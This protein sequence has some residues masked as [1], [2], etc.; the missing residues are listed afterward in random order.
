M[1]KRELNAKQILV[2]ILCAASMQV[3]SAPP[4]WSA[5]PVGDAAV[6]GQ[7]DKKAQ[8]DEADK[9]ANEETAEAAAAVQTEE[10]LA[11]TTPTIGGYSIS[12][13]GLGAS[14]FAN[15]DTIGTINV[16]DG[17]MTGVTKINDADFKAKSTNIAVGNGAAIGHKD[18]DIKIL[19]SVSVFGAAAQG[20]YDYASVFGASARGDGLGTSVFGVMAA[21][22]G[23]YSSVFGYNASAKYN[24]SVAIGANSNTNGINQVSFGD[25]VSG[26]TGDTTSYRSL[27][28]IS[29]ISLTGKIN[30]VTITNGALTGVTSINGADFVVDG[31]RIAVGVGA[32]TGNTGASAFGSDATAA[33][34]NAS[35]F[36]SGANAQGLDSSVFGY[37]AQAADGRATAFGSQAKALAMNSL[38]LGSHTNVN[39]T[40]SVAIGTSSATDAIDQ[41]AFG[42]MAD[43]NSFRSLA[44]IKDISL[45]GAINGVTITNGA[46]TGVTTINGNPVG[47][48]GS[49]DF[50][51]IQSDI[52]VKKDPTTETFKVEQATGNVTIA[53]NINGVG[54]INGALYKVT[55]I[56]EAN[57]DVSNGGTIVGIGATS[58]G[59]FG[60]TVFGNGA[61]GGGVLS[62][63]VGSQTKATGTN[64]IALG[65]GS[66]ALGAKSVVLGFEGIVDT[67]HAN[68]VAIGSGSKTGAA[69]Q[70]AFGDL[71][72]GGTGDPNTFRSLAG[73]KDIS[74]TGA[75][76]G[77]TITSGALSG[78]TTINGIDIADLGGGSVDFTD[79]KSNV[80]VK[81]ADN[82]ET[83]K[84]DQ[85]SGNVTLA[86]TVNGV[87]ISNGGVNGVAIGTKGGTGADSSN[88]MLGT[89][90]ITKMDSDVNS[91]N[92]NVNSL[93]TDVGALKTK[94]TNISYNAT[95]GTTVDGVT[96]KSGALTDVKTINGAKFAVYSNKTIAVGVNASAASDNASAFGYSATAQGM[97]SSAF[98]YDTRASGARASAF[99]SGAKAEGANSVA[100]GSNSQVA[101]NN[102]NSVAIG[103]GSKT[104]DSNQVAFGD[105][106]AGNTSSY[107]SLAGIKDI[108]LTG[109]ITGLA[110][111]TAN[112]DAVNL[113]QMNT[114]LD[115][116]ANKATTLAGY[117]IADAYTKAETY[118]RTEVDT[119]LGS[120]ADKT[121]VSALD[122][123]VGTAEG[124]I[125]SL[126]TN[127]ADKSTTLAGY[128]ITDAYTK[129][130]VNTEL[131][132]KADKST[133][134]AGYGITDAYTQAQVNTKLGEK[135]DVTTYNSKVS[136][137]E[138]ADNALS[139]RALA[140][141]TRTNKF[142]PDGTTLTGM[143]NI[144][145]TG[146][147]LGN[148]TFAAG[149]NISNVTTI[150]GMGITVT[151]ATAKTLTVGGTLDATTLLQGGK[152][153]YTAQE[154]DDKFGTAGGDVSALTGRVTT[155]EG[156]IT[157]LETNTAGITADGG[158]TKMANGF[159]VGTTTYGMDKTG[160]VT[161]NVISEGGVALS[162]KYAGKSAFDALNSTVTAVG[163]GLVAKTAALDANKADKTT[164]N[165]IDVRVGTAEGKIT[166]LETNKANK[167]NT[168]A[169]YGITDAYTQA[170]V[171]TKLGEKVDVTTYESKV[172]D[173]AN[174][175][176]ALSGR[177]AALETKT[178][179][180]TRS[181]A[182]SGTTT[183]EAATSFTNAGMATKHLQ[184]ETAVI[185]GVDFAANG[186]VTGVKTLN[187]IGIDASTR[188]LSN[189]GTYNGV[190][191]GSGGINGAAIT[192]TDFNGIN[193]TDLQDQVNSL[194]TSGEVTSQN[195]G[196]ITRTDTN[197]DGT[198]DTTTIEGA[199]KLTSSG[200]T[201]NK[202]S[203]SGSTTTTLENG[204]L[205][206][207]AATVQNTGFAVGS[208]SLNNGS[209]TVDNNN[210]LTTAGLTANK[211]TV[212]T[213]TVNGGKVSGLTDAALST[214]STEAVTG[215]Q[216]NSTNTTVSAMDA[217]YK[218]ADTVLGNRAAALETKTAG[219]S[220]TSTSGGTTTIEGATSFTNAG[221]ATKHLQ[222]ETA[223]IGGVDFAA[224]GAVTG[225]KTLNGIGID[226][227]GN[228][229]NAG[230]YN[231]VTIGNGG[232]NGATITATTFNG[233]TIGEGKINGVTI[234]NGGIN[235]ATITQTAFNGAAIT[236]STF[237][238]VNIT[239]LQNQVN[240]LGN[241]GGVTAENTGGITRTD[242]NSDGT[243]DTTTIEGATSFTNTG[244]ATKHLQADTAVI[245]GVDFA[246]GGAVTGITTLNGIGID[247]NGNLTSAG[248]YNGVTIGDGK[249][250]GVTIGNGGISGVSVFNGAT[251]TSTAFNGA[252]INSTSFNGVTIG[253]G[254]ING[255]VIGNGGINGAT[256]TNTDFN[257]VNITD[258]NATVNGSTTGLVDRTAAL[259]VNKVDVTTYESKVSDLANA[260]N[261]LSGRAAALETKTAG[262]DRTQTAG[263]TTT[264]EAATSFTNAGM[265][266]SNL[267]A[268]TAN[269]GG[270]DF[271]AGG[272]VTGITT[273]NG[274]GITVSGDA[275]KTLTVGGTLNATTLLQGGKTIYTAEEI[276]AKF[277]TTGD[278][279]NALTGRVGTLET[280][281]GGISRTE[282]SGTTTIEGATSFTNAGMATKHLQAD[283]ANI[284]GVTFAAGAAVTGVK[285]I[286]GIGI[287][288]SGNLTSAG[289]YNGV[290]I[291]D[292][293]IN[294]V[295][296][297]NGGI[298]GATITATAFN[299]A[300]I[301]STT[302]NSVNIT[303]L[304]TTVT[305]AGTGLVDRTGVLETNTAGITRTQT[306]GTARAAAEGMTTIETATS[307]TNAGMKTSNLQATTATIGDV[308]IAGGAVN[309]ITT[310]NG[311]GITVSG[312][313]A[314]T[315]TVGGTLDA[316]IL[317]QDGQGI[318]TAD[319]I[320]EKFNT[321]GGDVS[322][323]KGRVDTLETNT[324][325]IT[326]T[327]TDGDTVDDTT[328][329]E[330]ATSFMSDG[331]QTNH[332]QATTANI[333]GVDFGGLGAMTGVTTI[334]GISFENGLIGGVNIQNGMV[335]GQKIEWLNDRIH[336]L[337]NSMGGSGN[338]NPNTAGISRPDGAHTIIEGNTSIGVE[339]IKTNNLT[340]TD[341]IT[342]GK[343]KDSQTVIDKDGIKVGENDTVINAADGFITEKGLYIGVSGSDALDSAKF[344]IDQS[345][346]LSSTA[347]NFGFSNTSSGGA[348]FT[349]SNATTQGH[350]LVT[351]TTIKGNKVETGRIDTDEL[352]IGGNKVEITDGGEVKPGEH[353]DNHL[354]GTD[355]DGNK[356]TNDF[357]TSALNGTTQGAEKV[358][359]EDDR[360]TIK[361]TN[362]TSATGTSN[363][364][365]KTDVD[366]SDNKTVQESQLTT[367]ENG[368]KLNT[369]NTVTDKD[370]NKTSAS[371]GETT[372]TGDSLTVSKTTTTKDADGNDV[373]KTTST[374]VDS[375]EI[376]LN[377]EDGSSIRVGDAIEGLQSDVQELGG[378]INE[379]G[380]EIK[381]VGALSAALAGLHPQPQNANSKADFA[382]A[383]GSYEGKQALAVGAFYKPDKRVM[384]SMGASTT[385][386]K[387]MMN[388]GI[389]IALDRMPEAERA[390]Q[391][392]ERMALESK[393]LLKD[394]M[395]ELEDDYEAR[396]QKMEA[397]YE[398]RMQRLEARYARLQETQAKEQAAR[399]A[400]KNTASEQETPAAQEDAKEVEKTV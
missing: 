145:S 80:V 399:E 307:F 392:K 40:N 66:K 63:A 147:T 182:A 68:S 251:I 304:N 18:S 259:E 236:S 73:I 390:A 185:G 74:L 373:T 44:G 382:M 241:S 281:T 400:V 11:S 351:E 317:L 204:K 143:T 358:S 119:R 51:N 312:D 324:G 154:I 94:T 7:I 72:T 237:N 239:D 205:T 311:I 171:N 29:N 235:G 329:I 79:I 151:G 265:K 67:E 242:T 34:T 30:G 213:V 335:D 247:D 318:Y 341:S 20:N 118:N 219:I 190:T 163:T 120:K 110:N 23:Q 244:M 330:G 127:K 75:I 109:K 212:G 208:S 170:Q 264:I 107:R 91:L 227:S 230:I 43:H 173:L 121:T 380:V 371:S 197:S 210:K 166:S 249:I 344:S 194:G 253:E 138:G 178:A 369:S 169:G 217:A 99:G 354:E 136:A 122:G 298:N 337:E 200:L 24:N 155:A 50:T 308:T 294:G 388:M 343:D 221:M 92:T 61:S 54:I 112:T 1:S 56:N 295:T 35:A 280:K 326:R 60:N 38:A 168:L 174:A 177:A 223:A 362:N 261:A 385:T 340:A 96:I 196:G 189:A 140:L 59:A 175:D 393:D 12:P 141:E 195:T 149:G 252:T 332:L 144:T 193:I 254:K 349:D 133:T 305:A 315:L 378:R 258:L 49:V 209:L 10:V 183:I 301:T 108:A 130:E 137:L 82:T 279:V 234:G 339:G 248:T 90:D 86:G 160:N 179:G 181:D 266:T 89:V 13:R 250:N 269:I 296:V 46:L 359:A 363:T 187:G 146:A 229:T 257:G 231:G 76:N 375:G 142:N 129:T 159:K 21:A 53:G 117:G 309:G 220:R 157:T 4:V 396:L 391:E 322:V 255:V 47:S 215:K 115:G 42:N 84:V 165:A 5:Q 156:K 52:V 71:V 275:A 113:G 245:G 331:M 238:G 8:G 386:S 356:V 32:S 139:S 313:A 198:K 333:G 22:T 256:I 367:D 101:Y 353:I 135:V 88:I 263:G 297:G 387:H 376:T 243:K 104:N 36:G 134:L 202:V 162:A 158:T 211:V 350:G 338:I 347:G 394:R 327:D 206:V 348:K 150:N 383:M 267:Q 268:E 69:D 379:M 357:T 103:S 290:T 25:L 62:V 384:L 3:W 45:T 355:A 131:G 55:S 216:L 48:G 106:T 352:W 9:R 299:G 201:T 167:A 366:G 124:K 6:S 320:D 128:G 293:K 283:T 85:Y 372:M 188:N 262:I 240:D 125:T 78:V 16:T 214:S 284:G 126:E 282:A 226:V 95:S 345:G 300:E 161:A 228:L 17:A 334:N 225:V 199:T 102:A 123:R 176:N 27:A 87:N 288:A 325:G 77:L 302:F 98:G 285:T 286:N 33:W 291:G 14:T 105:L 377:R 114:A 360:D 389:S 31:D 381:E 346:N 272:A 365:T 132:N 39:H 100:L 70:V 64:S 81:K 260:D 306:G 41:V 287:D 395:K 274:I 314:K 180:I 342:V 2:A 111:G 218:A 292:G 271:A 192:S 97:D 398:A 289:T 397:T 148:V 278:N 152:K 328:T 374:K 116:K 93:N 57:F 164:V 207:G 222:A 186:A 65:A 26:A 232:I 83:F 316:K 368:M 191:I 19:R 364:T 153:L 270:V 276:N 233:V 361:T 15:P 273:L 224:G 28:G 184:A 319:E 321:S 37:A 246:A 58:N 323:L 310:I 172:H 303:D 370:G 203:V 277:D 336:V